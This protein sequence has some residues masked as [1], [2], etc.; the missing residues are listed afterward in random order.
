MSEFKPKIL[1]MGTPEFAAVQLRALIDAKADVAAVVCQPDSRG[2]R[3]MKLTAPPVAEA[4]KAAGIR[5]EQPETLKAGALLPLLN[6]IQPELIVVV[7][8]GRLLPEYVLSCP[9]LGCINLHGSLLPRYRGAAPIQRAVMAG[10]T[11]TGLSTMYLSKGMDEGDVIYEQTAEIGPDETAGELTERLARLGAPLLIK[12]I[13]DIAAGIA[14]RTAQN[15]AEA[16]FAPM[17]TKEEANLNFTMPA[18]ELYNMF[19]GLTP[20]PGARCAH[21][22]KTMKIIEMRMAEGSFT[23]QPGYIASA[24]KM[25]AVVV[26][27]DGKAVRLLKVAP[28]GKSVMPVAALVNGRGIAAGESLC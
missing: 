13:D 4:A 17:I 26:C 15:A 18:H 3:G 11:T 23:E 27:G 2:S 22:G 8:Y 20:N 5:L 1:Y 16:T 9:R 12:T 19:R 14:P 6:E 21:R 25:G 10:E 28:E 7:A 24:D